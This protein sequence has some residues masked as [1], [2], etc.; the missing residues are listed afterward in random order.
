M[1]QS[2]KYVMVTDPLSQGRVQVL[3]SDDGPPVRGMLLM[4]ETRRGSAL[5]GTGRL[6]LTPVQ[7]R[8]VMST[9]VMSSRNTWTVTTTSTHYR[10]TELLIQIPNYLLFCYTNGWVEFIYL[11]SC[12]RLSAA[13]GLTDSCHSLY[14]CHYSLSVSVHVSR[15]SPAPRGHVSSITRC[16]QHCSMQRPCRPAA[17]Q[18]GTK[19]LSMEKIHSLAQILKQHF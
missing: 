15:V 14:M 16:H 19:T 8:L 5:A 12:S 3:T 6:W 13:I 4:L 9:R 2:P 7:N 17:A 1:A 11:D 10:E 18:M